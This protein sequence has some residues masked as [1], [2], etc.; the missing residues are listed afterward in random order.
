MQGLGKQ[1]NKDAAGADRVCNEQLIR[2]V[3]RIPY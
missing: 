2:D 3:V 1:C